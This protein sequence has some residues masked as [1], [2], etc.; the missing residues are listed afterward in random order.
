L[1]ESGK[2]NSD[3]GTCAD[4]S[5]V[6]CT[7]ADQCTNNVCA[8]NGLCGIV[9][10]GSGCSVDTGG[11]L[12]QS[13]TCSVS[14]HCVP[15]GGSGCW[16]DGDCSAQQYCD[17]SAFT[18]ASKLS[19][20]DALPS[21]GLHD[22][23]CTQ[24]N[25]RALCASE[26][27][28][29]TTNTCAGNNGSTCSAAGQCV[30]GICGSNGR[31]GLP[32]GAGPCDQGNAKYVCQSST[33]SGTAG[34]CV[35]SVAL[36]CA[37][38][39]DCPEG[40]FCDGTNS[41]CVAKLGNGSPLPGD[42]LHSAGCTGELAVAVCQSGSCN[43][44]VQ[45]C[46]LAK[47]ESCSAAADCA[48][49]VCGSNGRCGLDV[50]Q[51][52]CTQSNGAQLC[53]SGVCSVA[54]AKC[55]AADGGCSADAD[56]LPD[57]FC[58][59]VT[60]HCAQRLPSGGP[61][62]SDTV[63]DGTCPASALTAVCTSGRCSIETN[64][65]VSPN[66]A[67]C[68]SNNQCASGTCGSNQRC[69]LAIGDGACQPGSDPRCQS[70]VCDTDNVCVSVAECDEDND[71]A[72]DETGTFCTQS[73][74][75]PKLPVGAAI[76]GDTHPEGCTAQ[77]AAVVCQTGHCNETSDTCAAARSG[78]CAVPAQCE[79]N[80]C[81]SNGQC[82]LPNGAGPCSAVS[83]G[84][85][86]QSGVCGTNSLMC[87]A[88]DGC[89]SDADCAI[90]QYCSGDTFKCAA[91]VQPGQP[92]P[93]DDLH[94]GVC[95]SELAERLCAGGECNTQSNTCALG[96]AE[97]CSSN[98]DCANN[99]CAADGKC[100]RASG[101]SCT[102]VR[103]SSCRS[104]VCSPSTLTCIPEMGCGGDG[105][106]ESGAYCDTTMY[107]CESRKPNGEEV[108]GGTCPSAGTTR[109]CESG[110][111]NPSTN[112]CAAALGGACDDP[113][114]CQSNVCGV[115]GQCG[116]EDGGKCLFDGQSL[117]CQSGS[118]LD[119]FCAEAAA[120]DVDTDC[121][122]GYCSDGSCRPLRQAG[123]PIPD[124]AEHDGTCT[125]DNARALCASGLCND[126]TN[127]CAGSFSA[128][129]A[130]AAFCV[131][132]VCGNDGTCGLG[133]GEGLCSDR[134][135][136]LTC[137][138]GLC[139]AVGVCRPSQSAGCAVDTD[140][141]ADTY[142]DRSQY[143]CVPRL[144]D[145]QPIPDDGLH[146]GAC[147]TDVASA[148][149]S[150]GVCN[151]NTNTCA[152]GNGGTCTTA[153]Q[154]VQDVC[155]SNGEC[156]IKEGDTTCTV[157]AQSRCQTGRCSAAMGR[158]IVQGDG[159]AVDADCGAT[160][161]CDPAALR[162]KTKLAAGAALSTDALHSGS[163]DAETASALCQSGACNPSTKTCALANSAACDSAAAC[164]SNVCG[165]NRR[166]GR[167][168]G[169][170]G[171]S[172]ASQSLDCQ[173]GHC[174]AS[175]A[176][177]PAQG[178]NIDTDCNSESYCNRTAHS[179]VIR[180]PDG[181]PLP[182]DGLHQGACNET[183]ASAVCRSGRC[184][185]QTNTC[186]AQ[187]STA[188]GVSE[189][190][191]TNYCADNGKCG[192][193]DGGGACVDNAECQSGQCQVASS[194][195]VSAAE[196]CTSDADCPQEA[197]CDVL[198]VRCVADLP[199]GMGIP[200]D[201][202]TGGRCT[203][204]IAE[205]YC[206]SGACNPDTDTCAELG[207]GGCASDADCVGNRCLDGTCGSWDGA[208]ECTE[209]NGSAVCASRRCQTDLGRCI[210]AE[211]GCGTDT[212]CS[213][214][215]YCDGSSLACVS[216]LSAGSKLP[217]SD[218]MHGAGCTRDVAAAVC[219]T[220]VCNAVTDACANRIGSDCESAADC[221]SN[222]CVRGVCVP[223]SEAP[224]AAGLS[225]GRCSVSRVAAGELA[226]VLGFLTVFGLLFWRR[227]RRASA[228]LVLSFLLL[229]TQRSS[230]Q[231]RGFAT[232]LFNPS[233]RGSEWFA[234]DSLD[235][236]GMLRPA[237][238]V[239]GS[240]A[241]RPLVARN[242]AG[243]F[244]RS[245]VRNQ[246]A[247]HPGVSLVV[248][249]RVRFGVDVP[250]YAL[251]DGRSVTVGTTTF[252]SPE[253]SSGLGDVR[254]AADLR[255]LGRYGDPFTMALGAQV[256]LPSGDRDSYLGDGVI[257]VLPQLSM[258]GDVQA[259]VYSARLGV[260]IR[261]QNDQFEQAVIGSYVSLLLA[262]G[263][264]VADK[265]LVIGP[266]LISQL[267]FVRDQ[268]FKRRSSPM[269]LMLGA[270]YTL[271]MGLR[272][273]A[274]FGIGVSESFR[275]PQHR[276]IV[277]VEWSP[278]IEE[279]KPEP[280]V[281]PDDP[282][283]R[284]RDGVSDALDACP[285]QV[286]ERNEDPT[287]NGCPA[288]ADRDQDGISDRDDACPDV[289]GEAQ[290][291]GCPPPDRDSDKVLDPQDACPDQAGV[292]DSDPARNGCP[293]PADRD[294]D[295]IVDSEDACPDAAGLPA[296]DPKRNGCPKAYVQGTQIKILDQV[297]F[298]TGKA[299]ILPGK[300]SQDVL[301]AVQQVL[302]EHPE[303]ESVRIEGHTDSTGSAARNRTLSQQRAQAV[304]E[305]LVQ[306]GI[307][308]TRLTSTGM[309]PDHP[310]DTND[311]EVGR[312]NNRRVEFQIVDQEHR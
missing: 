283:D 145:G 82:G 280:P 186:A 231:Q 137:R 277:S 80:V 105:D 55:L 258:A 25:A 17:R 218:A 298:Q 220:G 212:E 223:T 144:A 245:I 310:I 184:N 88:A 232:D 141:N 225:G 249:E 134:N 37:A 221:A 203:P 31:C 62:P 311:N 265:R 308:R 289:V 72:V 67:S 140:C 191:V 170:S 294:G 196:G 235:F 267:V 197:H 51:G 173:S 300:E 40:N 155:G 75:V 33:C 250:I 273:G 243:D 230:A 285:D 190:C 4:D 83:A 257:R 43:A 242:E 269:E 138:S 20:G 239:V 207:G 253:N 147:S 229:I 158:C 90:E 302:N 165:S 109:S 262:A 244:Q 150:S 48:L 295:N 91:R 6:A 9:T 303:V 50:D 205:T 120:C 101:E 96:A 121:T 238:G 272:I 61:L 286:G 172:S 132:N 211:N 21:D 149:C 206:A 290:Y 103:A 178:C 199:A 30:Q 1:C 299:V 3:T 254:L 174:A 291:N 301:E 47:G 79:T 159:C 78:S 111:C 309:G 16:A 94:D 113:A 307:Q 263:V 26:N 256:F 154:C 261:P 89:A 228:L 32:D 274:G 84:V 11:S 15:S 46:A 246:F 117:D 68:E 14:G 107:A 27:C 248:A 70:G 135:A 210:A 146:H 264:R 240:W 56:C 39:S 304:V 278:A 69:G 270:H 124:D 260:G 118:C 293:A 22:G 185:A 195:C 214:G 169:D 161:Y 74:C 236:R 217:K 133:T 8:A 252:E 171:C 54:T 168:V 176:C 156:G 271:P 296:A 192:I 287:R 268:F 87:A 276:G 59:G 19:N 167:A 182:K 282:E 166:C 259:F 148:V 129:C 281:L 108:F 163:C 152:L 10:G 306:H 188:C 110:H 255:L 73:E 160:Q 153:A 104:G 179:C 247:L 102:P 34:V 99:V 180:L 130:S 200:E 175:G 112:T 234:G 115:N 76:P 241:Y 201:A 85:V 226:P 208:G 284:D 275:A 77:N 64:R 106:C 189:Q 127:T 181:A 35:A 18:C 81:G 187:F 13:A 266:E 139:S 66:G 116:V 251:V 36:S 58:N 227:R 86:C 151:P 237:F 202:P 312:Q 233:E 29:P 28:N 209:E 52:S 23:R 92:L 216:L 297:K 5:N 65:C 44:S 213:G 128:A 222:A 2:C 12:C 100:G 204:E 125:A 114:D 7:E 122:A 219:D 305:W 162:C 57:D 292:P 224:P 194:T 49:N 41:V 136:S 97:E 164:V 126:T 279:P 123:D 93:K 288:P 71:C 98:A 63:H 142:C 38:D 193:V 183:L 177:V 143:L 215:S 42:A 53:Q 131:A 198:A 95:T 60:K 24:P 157:E 119:G 45:R